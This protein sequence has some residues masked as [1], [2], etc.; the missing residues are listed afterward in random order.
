MAPLIQPEAETIIIFSL[1]Q[2]FPP[3]IPHQRPFAFNR[4]TY[5]GEC[6][7]AFRPRLPGLDDLF[8]WLSINSFVPANQNGSLLRIRIASISQ[9]TATSCL[10]RFDEKENDLSI[11]E[12]SELPT[13]YP[14]CEYSSMAW[15]NDTCYGVKPSES[16]AK[17]RALVA[18]M[19]TNDT[20]TYRPIVS[21][22]KDDSLDVNT[23]NVI[24]P[25]IANGEYV[26][27]RDT[28]CFYILCFDDNDKRPRESGS[29]FDMG[30]LE[31]LNLETS[32]SSD[33]RMSSSSLSSIGSI[34]V[35]V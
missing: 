13:D 20:K 3:N 19:G 23:D 16:Y 31:V 24:A 30:K 15:W 2:R 10:L 7:G 35:L 28:D 8:P 1:P 5:S 26:I 21:K 9:T 22:P 17:R 33:S 25:I 34:G 12:E 18:Y 32:S 29:F 14:N 11:W 6:I 27:R 4:Y